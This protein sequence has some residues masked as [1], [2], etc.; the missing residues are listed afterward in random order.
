MKLFTSI[1]AAAAVIGTSSLIATP[2]EAGILVILGE[3]DSLV[4]KVNDGNGKIVLT[5]GSN[6]HSW[7]MGDEAA[8]PNP[9]DKGSTR[10]LLLDDTD[11]E[12]ANAK[13][14]RIFH[15]GKKIYHS[16]SPDIKKTAIQDL[17]KYYLK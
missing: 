11:E 4:M 3:K 13:F 9:G 10:F 8:W 7:R 14:W 6:S 16:K 5:N 12:R 2:C 15:T 1:A 17:Y